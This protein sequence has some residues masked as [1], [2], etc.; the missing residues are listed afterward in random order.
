MNLSELMLLATG[1]AFLTAWS[2]L[3]VRKVKKLQAQKQDN[4]YHAGFEKGV[5]KGRNDYEA[6]LRAFAQRAAE[7]EAALAQKASDLGI[8]YS[9]SMS[10]APSKKKVASK[11]KKAAPKKKAGKK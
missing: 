5:E 7:E 10:A 4:A 8:S 6:E 1:A 11:K 9:V 2:V 3:L